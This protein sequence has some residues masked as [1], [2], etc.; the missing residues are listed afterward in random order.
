[1]TSS[2]DEALA[3]MLGLPSLAVSAP[4][5]P[6]PP[7]VPINAPPN[8]HRH[9]SPAPFAYLLPSLLPP[10]FSSSLID[11]GL[12]SVPTYI[13]TATHTADDGSTSSVAIKSPNQHKVAVLSSPRH[14]H[15]LWA[16]L[17]PIVRTHLSSSTLL[18]RLSDHYSFALTPSS[19]A[20]NPRLRL[21]RYDASTRDDFKPH[22]DATTEDLKEKGSVWRS[23]LTVLVYLNTGSSESSVCG[24]IVDEPSFAGGRTLF[25]N[26]ANERAP[27]MEVGPTTGSVL[28]FE[29]DMFHAG[30]VVTEGVKWIMRTDVF[31]R[32]GES[33]EE[34]NEIDQRDRNREEG[35]AVKPCTVRDVLGELGL[36]HVEDALAEMGMEGSLETFCGAGREMVEMMLVEAVDEEQARRIWEKAMERRY[37]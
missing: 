22:F 20:L 4:P 35:G 25:L 8:N 31:F 33:I 13:T 17:E 36:E 26:P 6:P 2:D 14:H 10:S 32:I 12:T 19:L 28:L 3:E 23:Y 30:E 1:M 9:S 34:I 18:S 16:Q 37:G 11:L 21:L 7:C 15:A 24:E 5:S 29:H 27:A